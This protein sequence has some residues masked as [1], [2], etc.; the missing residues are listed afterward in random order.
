MPRIL[1]RNSLMSCDALLF[2]KCLFL[3]GG[4]LILN[5]S[6]HS[7]SNTTATS[8][9]IPHRLPLSYKLGNDEPLFMQ[10]EC[11]SVIQSIR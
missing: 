10:H 3:A 11:T 4:S 5:C 6:L 9:F 1:L 2:H 8:A 7:F